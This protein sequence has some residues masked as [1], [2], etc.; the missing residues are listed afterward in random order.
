MMTPA[1]PVLRFSVL[2][3]LQRVPFR[4][5]PPRHVRT[6]LFTD[7][8]FLLFY[9]M[10]PHTHSFS[11]ELIFDLKPVKKEIELKYARTEEETRGGRKSQG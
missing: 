3:E 1:L 4:A 11:R 9:S 10:N 5:Y 7:H 8:L 6:V 2:S